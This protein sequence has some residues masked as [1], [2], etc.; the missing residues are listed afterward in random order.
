[1]QDLTNIHI[2]AAMYG[3]AIEITSR[4]DKT[5]SE[6]CWNETSSVTHDPYGYSKLVAEREAWKISDL[7][8]R[9]D[10]VVIN[11]GLVLGP[12]LSPGSASGS[13]FMLENMYQGNDKMGCPELFFSLVDVR[14]VAW[15]HVKAG[16]TP[17]AKGRYL[18]AGD[19]TISLL[20]MAD[21]VRPIHRNPK[22]LPRR[23]LPKLLV[24]AAG[25]FIGVSF[26][27]VSRNLG[28]QFQID[29]SKSVR[30][31]GI[32]YRPADKVLKDHYEAWLRNKD[33]K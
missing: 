9:W 26:K 22:V 11:P 33:L 17:A 20:G 15:A 3:D 32:S 29:N 8:T 19:R 28:I 31:L 5:V 1:M 30:E 12:S 7:Q 14:D 24:Y 6:T 10:L 16:T 18:I 21:L 4:E 13:L 23:N 2:V 27:W 25:P